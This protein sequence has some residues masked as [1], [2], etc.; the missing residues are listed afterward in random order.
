MK[1]HSAIIGHRR[2]PGPPHRV[3]NQPR[4]QKNEAGVCQNSAIGSVSQPRRRSSGECRMM[5]GAVKLGSLMS[6][7]AFRIMIILV[8]PFF[9]S[10]MAIFLLIGFSGDSS[11]AQNFD[12]TFFGN[13]GL[14]ITNG[15]LTVIGG[16]IQGVTGT[17]TGGPNSTFDGL[18]TSLDP[19]STFSY[20]SSSNYDI[21]FD[22]QTANGGDNSF[23]FNDN[24]ARDYAFPGD[25][26]TDASSYSMQPVGAPAPV[27]GSG[28]LSYLLFGFVGLWFRA[29]ASWSRVRHVA[30][31]TFARVI[32]LG[33][34]RQKQRLTAAHIEASKSC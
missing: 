5:I 21:R 1:E 25:I 20:T 3:E 14:Q 9:T 33:G 15:V 10:A 16:N 34:S 8:R 27:V 12:F 4:R 28:L 6:K 24:F 13:N 29:K 32:S 30:Q 23:D 26:I 31:S 19:G 11:F 22:A 18:I 7:V 2:S 17:I